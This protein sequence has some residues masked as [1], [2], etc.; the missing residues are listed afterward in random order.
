MFNP[1]IYEWKTGTSGSTEHFS[2]QHQEALRMQQTQQGEEQQY[3]SSNQQQQPFIGNW[4]PQ[5]QSQGQEQQFRRQQQELQ[6]QQQQ[7]QQQQLQQQLQ[8]QQPLQQQQLQQEQQL[9][10]QSGNV[11][12]KAPPRRRKST[13]TQQNSTNQNQVSSLSIQKHDKSLMQLKNT[14]ENF[15]CDKIY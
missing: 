6:Q 4:D 8:Q 7:L 13:K 11:A 14:T 9:Q 2:T 1:G 12:P 3:Q 5:I 10:Q 15:N